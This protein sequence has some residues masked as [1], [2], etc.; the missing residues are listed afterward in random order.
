VSEPVVD[1]RTIEDKLLRRAAKFEH[2]RELY[3]GGSA[4]RVP[5]QS[6]TGRMTVT[7]PPYHPVRMRELGD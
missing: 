4:K 7:P 1:W 3:G 6:I 5:V 2:F